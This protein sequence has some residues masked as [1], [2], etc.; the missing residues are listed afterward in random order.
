MKKRSLVIISLV[1]ILFLTSCGVK[2][3]SSVDKLFIGI[4]TFDLE[5]IHSVLINDNVE[6]SDGMTES[7]NNFFKKEDK[8]SQKILEYCKD[9]ANKIEYK[10]NKSKIE[11]DKAIVDVSVKYVDSSGL[12]AR[13]MS[14]FMEEA[15]ILA[16][17]GGDMSDE[18]SQEIF[19]SILES[20]I[21]R[22]E[23]RYIEKDLKVYLIKKDNEWY[24]EELNDDLLNIMFTNFISVLNAF[25]DESSLAEKLEDKELVEISI[26]NSM[27]LAT[28]D[29]KV[30][31]VEE[32]DVLV[33]DLFNEE[34]YPNEGAKFILLDVDVKNIT[35]ESFY[36]NT[37]GFT[38][39]DSEHRYFE[40]YD[41]SIGAIE[42]YIEMR[43]MGPSIIENGIIVYQVPED[44]KD[45]SLI[46][47]HGDTNISYEMKLK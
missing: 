17:S 33:N 21:E 40:T 5:K 37:Y 23:D 41:G 3:E 34:T 11:G 25:D 16:F 10:I 35:K 20:E 44:S 30:N 4:K 15:I 45:Y 19:I 2:P 18:H 38:L 27:E 6:K 1:L 29:V 39:R 46:M 43:T 14:Q 8:S 28:I 31:N 36:L 13:T 26:D 32:T 22:S 9:K 42:N 7:F 47:T 12:M 24:I